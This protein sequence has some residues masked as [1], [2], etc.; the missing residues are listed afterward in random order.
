MATTRAAKIAAPPA[1]IATDHGITTPN[2]G[3]ASVSLPAS[4]V[5]LASVRAR[6]HG[7]KGEMAPAS[8]LTSRKTV[9]LSP[10]YAG[11]DEEKMTPVENPLPPFCKNRAW[12]TRAARLQ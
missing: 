11:H 6:G 5:M 12:E 10:S 3:G 2:R 4:L 7:L 9:A 8:T 1:V